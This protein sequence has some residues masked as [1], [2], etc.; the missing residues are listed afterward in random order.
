M[1]RIKSKMK[2][3]VQITALK[4]KIDIGKN[5]SRGSAC[6]KGARVDGI[7]ERLKKKLSCYSNA[8]TEL[9][10]L[11]LRKNLDCLSD[12]GLQNPNVKHLEKLEMWVRRLNLRTVN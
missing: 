9:I 4:D 12:H 10:E 8:I 7:Q 11:H 2:H 1:K 5:T 6:R 3:V